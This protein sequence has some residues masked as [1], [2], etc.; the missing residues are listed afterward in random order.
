[1]DAHRRV[2]D[3]KIGNGSRAK[4]KER[5]NISRH[6]R[7]FTDKKMPKQTRSGIKRKLIMV[8]QF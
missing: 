6:R 3:K 4:I 5:N 8:R 7:P 2:M 1:M